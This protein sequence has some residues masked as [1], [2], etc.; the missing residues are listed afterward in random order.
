MRE[1]K[2]HQVEAAL[3]PKQY[4]TGGKLSRNGFVDRWRVSIALPYCDRFIT[5][6]A[7]LLK[8]S[9]RVKAEFHFV[10]AEISA[11]NEFIDSVR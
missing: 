9:E 7:R 3:R 1:V 10:A 5:S 11:G 2:C 6:D 4:S 8:A